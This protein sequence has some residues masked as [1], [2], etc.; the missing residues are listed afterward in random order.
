[1][2]DEEPGLRVRVKPT[3]KFEDKILRRIK[4]QSA[5]DLVAIMVRQPPF[6]PEF[7]WFCVVDLD[8]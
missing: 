3:I 6:T 4:S 1:M 2:K 8:R 7:E 5:R